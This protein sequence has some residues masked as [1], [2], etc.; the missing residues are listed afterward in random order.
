MGSSVLQRQTS[1]EN[2]SKTKLVP[3]VCLTNNG[4]VNNGSS[5]DANASGD[6]PI[7]TVKLL[8]AKLSIIKLL[9]ADFDAI[10]NGNGIW[11]RI[12]IVRSCRDREFGRGIEGRDY[13]RT[14]WI[15][16]SCH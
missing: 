15:G 8:I 14:R 2:R 12:W 6:S 16:G 4:S 10:T 11:R 5:N 3:C 7:G 1:R 9:I 13:Y